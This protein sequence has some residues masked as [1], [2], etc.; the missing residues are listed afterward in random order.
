M[1]C[2]KGHYG[3]HGVVQDQLRRRVRHYA[4]RSNGNDISD[5][6]ETSLADACRGSNEDN[7]HIGILTVFGENIVSAGKHD[8]AED[9]ETRAARAHASA[10]E[11][12]PKGQVDRASATQ[13]E[14]TDCSPAKIT[15]GRDGF[16]DKREV[17]F[18]GA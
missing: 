9:R 18:Q 13:R 3:A 6:A 5:C 16:A 2:P 8:G 7:I 14:T 1:A 12:L 10:T 4:A 17:H 11:P 15:E